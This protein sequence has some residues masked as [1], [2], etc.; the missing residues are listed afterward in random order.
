MAEPCRLP[1]GCRA[2]VLSARVR[3]PH[4]HRPLPL[5]LHPWWER[6]APR[7][8][9]MQSMTS[10][11]SPLPGSTILHSGNLSSIR[12]EVIFSLLGNLPVSPSSLTPW[13]GRKELTGAAG[14][15]QGLSLPRP[16]PSP[17]SPPLLAFAEGTGRSTG[18]PSSPTRRVPGVR[19][20]R[21]ASRAALKPGTTQGGSVVSAPT[22]GSDAVMQR[23]VAGCP[24]SPG[25]QHP[26]RHR[27]DLPREGPLS[28]SFLSDQRSPGTRVA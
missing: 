14:R 7:I 28:I 12:L 6:A 3:H 25:S 9:A 1:L 4:T 22:S 19:S 15:Q 26:G 16:R 18:R 11:Q 23:R 13:R 8:L 17:C 10:A 2:G 27:P 5:G 20:A 21:P 24:R